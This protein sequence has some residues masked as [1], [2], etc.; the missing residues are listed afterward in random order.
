MAGI[1]AARSA[2]DV[3]VWAL[4]EMAEAFEALLHALS[5]GAGEAE[6]VRDLL[7]ASAA[8]LMEVEH[9]LVLVLI[10]DA[11]RL[12]GECVPDLVETVSPPSLFPY[13]LRPHPLPL[14]FEDPGLD[15]VADWLVQRADV[16]CALPVCGRCSMPLSLAQ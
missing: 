13:V 15:G 1:A 16:F 12:L 8:S 10:S 14:A 7:P 3:S 9:G 6:T 5:A 4:R 2:P 11:P